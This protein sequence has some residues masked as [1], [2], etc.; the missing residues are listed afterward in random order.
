MC[1]SGI[2]FFSM[3]PLVVRVAESYNII[4]QW[5]YIGILYT[6]N[7]S[8]LLFHPTNTKS[9]SVNCIQCNYMWTTNVPCPASMALLLWR[10]T[11]RMRWISIT[12][13]VQKKRYI[14]IVHSSMHWD[15][16]NHCIC[17]ISKIISSCVMWVSVHC[18]YSILLASHTIGVYW[19]SLPEPPIFQLYLSSYITITPY[20]IWYA[21]CT[22][23]MAY[24]FDPLHHTTQH[25]HTYIHA[26]LWCWASRAQCIYI[27]VG[28][29]CIGASTTHTYEYERMPSIRFRNVCVVG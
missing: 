23:F 28:C 25:I 29:G 21:I 27:L 9:P 4:P 18:I 22:W 8:S 24:R 10:K 20:M 15:Y 5:M 12:F 26:E 19:M 2:R 6:T 17:H 7:C 14:Y 11:A 1:F 13:V 3:D 16:N